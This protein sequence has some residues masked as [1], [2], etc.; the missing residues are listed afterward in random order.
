MQ[1]PPSSDVGQTSYYEVLGVEKG[2]T[3]DEIKKA[4]RKLAVKSHPDKG[5]DPELF[6]Q[7]TEAYEVLSDA[8]KRPLYDKYGKEGLETGGGG[9][10]RGDIFEQMFGGGRGG[11]RARG[12]RLPGAVCPQQRQMATNALAISATDLC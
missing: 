7:I 12:G 1:R 8:E 4:Y 10:G 2:A 5:G 11:R 9:R 3:Q 6:K